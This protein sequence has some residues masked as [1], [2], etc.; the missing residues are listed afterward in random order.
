LRG[1]FE[2]RTH[3]HAFGVGVDHLSGELLS[4]FSFE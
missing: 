3:H 4:H 1:V 2:V